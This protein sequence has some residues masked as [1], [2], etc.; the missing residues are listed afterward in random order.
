MPNPFAAVK[1]KELRTRIL[2]IAAAVIVVGLIGFGTAALLKQLKVPTASQNQAQHTPESAS[3]AA[4]PAEALKTAD[5]AKAAAIDKIAA[6]KQVDAKKDY[7]TA[8]EN[9]KIAGN[10]AEAKDALFAVQSIQAVIDAP[11]NPGKSV[12]GETSSKDAAGN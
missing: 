4:T 10:D 6:G 7:Q 9:Y 8:Y 12:G 1:Q 11:K 2:V 5:A 3:P